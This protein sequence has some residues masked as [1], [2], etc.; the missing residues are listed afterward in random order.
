MQPKLNLTIYLFNFFERFSTVGLKS[1]LVLYL[2]QY[3]SYEPENAAILL[4]I[5]FFWEYLF[6]T[7]IAKIIERFTS[8]KK[9]ILIGFLFGFAGTI[10]FFKAPFVGIACFN[11][12][13]ASIKTTLPHFFKNI[14]RFSRD[15]N[16]SQKY[17]M[18]HMVTN[19]SALITALIMGYFFEMEL[20]SIIIIC[21]MLSAFLGILFALRLFKLR[22]LK[23]SKNDLIFFFIALCSTVLMG[24]SYYLQTY[25][26]SFGLGVSGFILYKIFKFYSSHPASKKPILKQMFCLLIFCYLY[27]LFFI[28]TLSNLTIIIEEFTNRDVFGF[29]IPTPWFF[30]LNSLFVILLALYKAKAKHQSSTTDIIFLGG[31]ILCYSSLFFSVLLLTTHTAPIWGI[32]CLYLALC[33]AEVYIIPATVS[34]I[35]QNAPRN[36]SNFYFA[37][38]PTICAFASYSNVL[39]SKFV[40]FDTENLIQYFGLFLLA[41]FLILLLLPHQL[42]KIF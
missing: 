5:F 18:Y 21:I 33:F 29:E 20:L 19:L 40:F 14:I 30:A 25:F 8:D 3:Q 24:L 17:M 15:K 42:K 7:F 9:T 28:Q 41:M 11:F 34:F 13:S 2:I 23:L 4:S 36:K 27:F 31:K 10:L 37:L 22:E 16:Y 12:A 35:A 6:A 26:M 32:L 38:L 1:F 39:L